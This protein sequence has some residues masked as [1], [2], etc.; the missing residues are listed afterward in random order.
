VTS[1]SAPLAPV[2]LRPSRAAAGGWSATALITLAV[3][4]WIVVDSRGAVLAWL[5]ATLVALVSVFFLWQFLLP[6]RFEV[7]LGSDDLEATLPWGHRRVA[8]EHVRLARVVRVTG[9]PILELHVTGGSGG[10]TRPVGVLL[11]LGADLDALHG[12]LEARLGRAH[13]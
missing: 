11:P 4:G 6:G 9:E 1:D 8:W 3:A 12:F 5:F 7:R 10:D 2:V 13:P